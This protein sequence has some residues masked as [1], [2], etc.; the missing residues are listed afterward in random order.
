MSYRIEYLLETTDEG[1]V[2]HA[3][4][5]NAADLDGA[6]R[7]AFAHAEQARRLGDTGFQIRHVN[8][9]DEVVSIGQFE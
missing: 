6:E 2:C 8:A 5:S 3:V 4:A 1:T 9:V 7:E